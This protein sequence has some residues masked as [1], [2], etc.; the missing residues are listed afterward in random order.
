MRR[1]GSKEAKAIMLKPTTVRLPDDLLRAAK[2]HGIKSGRS[3]QDMVAEAL[4][5]YLKAHR[6]E[7]K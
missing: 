6:A 3:L 1:H 5:A 2:I 4:A 7:E